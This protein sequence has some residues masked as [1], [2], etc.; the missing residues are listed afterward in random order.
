MRAWEVQNEAWNFSFSFFAGF[1][2]K[3][4]HIVKIIVHASQ[5][6]IVTG[7]NFFTQLYVRAGL[8]IIMTSRVHK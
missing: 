1:V 8:E 5:I 7:K 4:C 2:R 3:F 6:V